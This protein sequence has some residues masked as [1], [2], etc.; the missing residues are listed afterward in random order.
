MQQF[1]R[2]EDILA[3]HF[4]V[5]W[6]CYRARKLMLQRRFEA[7]WLESRSKSDFIASILRGDISL[8]RAKNAS[9]SGCSEADLLA[10]LRNRGFPTRAA[11]GRVR[12]GEASKL[13]GKGTGEDRDFHYLLGMP[14]QSFTEE[15]VSFTSVSTCY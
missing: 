3:E 4:P 7:D 6:D 12:D 10:E 9:S 14:I 11:I 1:E 5:R 8:M 2:P 15:K 13:P